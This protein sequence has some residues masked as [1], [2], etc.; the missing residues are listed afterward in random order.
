MGLCALC[1]HA[2]SVTSARGS[3]FVLC[4]RSA[5]DPRFPKYPAL[6]VLRCE[7]VEPERDPAQGH[8]K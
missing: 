6:P 4:G 5:F 7:G 1:R 8:Q 3:T 2:R